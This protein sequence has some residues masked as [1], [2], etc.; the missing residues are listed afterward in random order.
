MAQG[1]FSKKPGFQVAQ[2]PTQLAAQEARLRQRIAGKGGIANAPRYA[3]RLNQVQ[4]AQLSAGQQPAQPTFDTTTGQANSA[5]G[6]VFQQIGN[7]QPMNMDYG[8]MRQKAEQVAMDS[9]NRNMQPQFQREE[10]AFRQRMAEQ[11]IDPNGEQARRQFEQLKTQQNSMTQNAMTGAFQAGQG[12]QAQA[13]NQG[14]TGQLLPY[15]KLGALTPFYSSQA[16]ANLQGAQ[17]T[18][19]AKQNEMNRKAAIEQA[20]INGGGNISMADRFALMD[21]ETQQRLVL[22]AQQAS[23]QN[24][25]QMPNNSMANGAISGIAQGVGQ[26]VIASTLR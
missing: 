23:L 1:A 14:V 3:N 18:W 25:Q 2:D 12:E 16:N 22:Q 24:G 6:N 19:Q 9:F 20:R 15:Q 8:S 4:Q 21:A 13:F 17:N 7:L 26:G 10:E 5:M 11:G